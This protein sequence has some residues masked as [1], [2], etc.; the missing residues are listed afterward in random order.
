MATRTSR[1]FR[2]PA[3]LL[4][5]TVIQWSVE[6]EIARRMFRTRRMFRKHRR[7]HPA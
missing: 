7:G 2:Y 3:S 5:L 4:I 6:D 1:A